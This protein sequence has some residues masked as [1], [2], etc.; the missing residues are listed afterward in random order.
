MILRAK[1][2]AE[3]TSQS[4]WGSVG[5][6]SRREEAVPGRQKG[7]E[8]QKRP[9]GIWEMGAQI[10]LSFLQSCEAPKIIQCSCEPQNV[11]EVTVT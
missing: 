4:L 6:P 5:S 2:G 10:F 1:C 3:A 11:T 7:L 9:R 8:E